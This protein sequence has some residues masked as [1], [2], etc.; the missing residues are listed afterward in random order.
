MAED[1]N[2]QGNDHILSVKPSIL[3][4]CLRHYKKG[5]GKSFNSQLSTLLHVCK[6]QKFQKKKKGLFNNLGMIK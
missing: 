5:I 1:I 6:H 3:S 2:L 4:K